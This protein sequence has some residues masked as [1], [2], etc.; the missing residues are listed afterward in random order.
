MASTGVIQIANTGWYQMT[1]GII[2]GTTSSTARFAVMVN[3]G[4]GFVTSPLGPNVAEIDCNTGSNGLT[5]ADAILQ[6]ITVLIHVTAIP[7]TVV[8]QNIGGGSVT[9]NNGS[10]SAAGGP[11]AYATF[12]RI[13]N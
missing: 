4:S 9:L 13:S 5:V 8:I 6:S 10:N 12:I 7:A 3:N 2:I 1:W 11:C